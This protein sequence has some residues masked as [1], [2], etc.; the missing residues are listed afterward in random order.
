MANED[1]REAG[2]LW[3]RTLPMQKRLFTA[4]TPALFENPEATLEAICDYFRWCDAEQHQSEQI[5]L[6]RGEFKRGKINHMRAYTKQGCCAFIG[7]SARTWDKWLEGGI[8]TGP[9]GSTRSIAKIDIIEKVQSILEWATS[10]MYEQKF[11]GAAAGL[12]NASVII[13]ELKL[14]DKIETLNDT[15]VT[16]TTETF[17]NAESFVKALKAMGERS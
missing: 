9:D 11:T 8:E 15:N 16:A 17:A 5:E 6:Y 3:L 14:S 1:A 4:A 7:V 12:L 2:K 10:V 13:R